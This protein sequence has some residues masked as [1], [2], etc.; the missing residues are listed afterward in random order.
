MPTSIRDKR[1]IFIMIDVSQQLVCWPIR[2][3]CFLCLIRL[4]Y[5]EIKVRFSGTDVCRFVGLQWEP[6]FNNQT[7]EHEKQSLL[8][9]EKKEYISAN[10][11]LNIVWP[12]WF[13]WKLETHEIITNNRN[14][15]STE[16]T[17]FH[18]VCG[19]I[20]YLIW[21]I[22]LKFQYNHQLLWK[23]FEIFLFSCIDGLL[24]ITL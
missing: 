6:D 10:E 5:F 1:D 21:S 13:R 24:E 7:A 2:F 18:R 9:Q 22:S 15:F 17:E 8:D 12:I 20:L 11:A 19:Q 3:Y 23:Q 16:I 14:R 4:H